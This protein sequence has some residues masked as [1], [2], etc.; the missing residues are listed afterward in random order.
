MGAR[1]RKSAAEL[2][3]V[4]P[5]GI[6]FARRPEPP[7]HLG[8]DAAATWRSITN[9]VPADWFGAGALPLLEALCGLTVSQRFTIRSL[10]KIERGGDDFDRDEWERLIKQ[11]GEV[12]G[13]VATLASLVPARRASSI[14]PG[15]A[16]R[17]E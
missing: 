15:Q 10:Q 11:L 12:S 13:R 9:S 2:S 5:G 14:D 16:L 17:E 3:T 8:D 7:A 6:V 4:G 1:G